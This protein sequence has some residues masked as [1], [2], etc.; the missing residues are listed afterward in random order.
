VVERTRG[1]SRAVGAG[2]VTVY[3]ITVHKSQGLTLL[4]VVLNLDQ[5]EHCLGLLYVAVS[6]VKVLDRLM[7]K[8]SFDYSQ[9][10]LHN[11]STARD[12][13]LDI[14]FRKTQLL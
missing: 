11:T 13:E 10:N 14:T 2:A 5:R 6:Q 7:F 9:F 12:Q 3:T 8:S 1:N 4:Q